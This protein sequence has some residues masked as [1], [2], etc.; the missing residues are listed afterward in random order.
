M[1]LGNGDA[2]LVTT[3]TGGVGLT[4]TICALDFEEKIIV[5]AITI[6]IQSN[7]FFILTFAIT[8]YNDKITKL[9]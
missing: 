9:V 2:G 3:V 8:L 4:T 6:S 1:A 7:D 5:P